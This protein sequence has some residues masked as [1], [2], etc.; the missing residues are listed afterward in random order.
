ME[1]V[2]ILLGVIGVAALI[3]IFYVIGAYNNLVSVRN[4]FKNAYAQIDVQLKRRYD[5]IPNLVE[6]AKGYLQHERAT[7]DEVTTARNSAF[8]ANAKA[9]HNPGNVEAIK[10]IT[11]AEAALVGSLGRLFAVV[12]AY[13]NLKAN[14]EMIRL[15]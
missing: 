11:G 7:L 3:V 4:R 1:I 9:A 6:T 14:E 13:P 8:S 2:L 5:L 12:E 15:M 10:Q